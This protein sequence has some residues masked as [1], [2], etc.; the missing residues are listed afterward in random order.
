[1]VTPRPLKILVVDDDVNARTALGALLRDEQHE[2]ELAFDGVDALAKLAAFHAD[3]IVTDVK[4][5]HVD[6]LALYDAVAR[7]AMPTPRF[8]FVSARR[9]FA[10]ERLPSL[11]G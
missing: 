11:V 1:M 6:G 8:V 9:P 5:P 4:R 10:V 7:M 3:V 2:V